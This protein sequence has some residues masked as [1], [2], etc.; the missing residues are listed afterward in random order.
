MAV[1]PNRKYVAVSVQVKNDRYPQ[2]VIYSIRNYLK[3]LGDK[4]KT[5][6]YTDTKSTQF[7]AMAFSGGDARFLVCLTGP[8]NY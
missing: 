1:A 8:P 2:I 5:F 3:G 4:E 6:R 7:T